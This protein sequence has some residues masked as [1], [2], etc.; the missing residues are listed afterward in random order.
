MIYYELNITYI[1]TYLLY[2][3]PGT[4]KTSFIKLLANHFKRNIAYLSIQ[5]DMTDNQLKTIIKTIP[6]NSILCLEDRFFL[7]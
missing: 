4:G 3:P 6:K 7:I 1:R 2:G 5:I